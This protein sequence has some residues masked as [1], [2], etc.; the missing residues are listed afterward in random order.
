MYFIV[1]QVTPPQ[2][3]KEAREIAEGEHVFSGP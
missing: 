3:L 1:F 2:T